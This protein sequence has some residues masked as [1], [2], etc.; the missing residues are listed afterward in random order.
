MKGVRHT[1]ATLALKAGVPVKVVSERLGHASTSFTMDTY[2]HVLPGMQ[3]DA[4]EMVAGLVAGSR[5]Q[6][7]SKLD[8]PP[9]R[10]PKI[11]SDLRFSC[12]GGI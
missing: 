1:H 5:V 10:R 8:E 9:T 6:R 4:A 11:G 7:V 12:R 3:E 2:A